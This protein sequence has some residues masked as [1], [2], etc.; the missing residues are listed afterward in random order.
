MKRAGL[1]KLTEECGELLVVIGK[2][3]AG[4]KP[5]RGSKDMTRALEQE[6][7]DVQAA[8]DYVIETHGLSVKYIGKRRRFKLRKQRRKAA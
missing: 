1:D 4:G 3:N 2:A 6:I 5:P 8:C 7:A